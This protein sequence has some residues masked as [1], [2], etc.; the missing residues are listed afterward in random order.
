[1]NRLPFLLLA[2]L[3]IL[4]CSSEGVGIKEG[5][6]FSAVYRSVKTT[7]AALQVGVNYNGLGELIQKMATEISI[8]ED[9]A[10]S[11]EDKEILNEYR[12]ITNMYKDSLKAWGIAI[13][14]RSDSKH[15]PYD[16]PEG[17][18]YI[19]DDLRPIISMYTIKTTEHK[20][21]IKGGGTYQMVEANDVR[22]IIW[23]QASQEFKVLIQSH[24]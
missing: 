11:K 15:L 13:F 19:N 12:K 20:Q 10:K 6:K 2:C 5:T 3:V 24:P 9:K 22:Q 23:A 1:V 17:W 8:V 7:Q 18:L 14:Q 21:Q 16:L 4:G